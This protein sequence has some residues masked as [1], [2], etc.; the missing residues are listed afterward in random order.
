VRA[1]NA[2]NDFT[3]ALPFEAKPSHKVFVI[4]TGAEAA[5]QP[6]PAGE[7][8]LSISNHSGF[9]GVGGRENNQRCF[10]RDYGINMTACCIYE[11]ACSRFNAGGMTKNCHVARDRNSAE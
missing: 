4:P 1:S 2:T 11:M 3:K 10:S 7:T 9:V 5:T 6:G 8:G